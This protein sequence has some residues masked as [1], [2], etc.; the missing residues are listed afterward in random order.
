MADKEK[1][2]AEMEAPTG[3]VQITLPDYN[4][5]TPEEQEKAVK[6]MELIW[7]AFQ[8][9][10]LSDRSCNK[11]PSN[12]LPTMFFDFSGHISWIDFRCHMHG[13]KDGCDTDNPDEYQARLMRLD[14]K[15]ERFFEEADCLMGWFHDILEGMK[16]DA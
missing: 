4:M 2:P 1:R 15:K 5:F 10:G 7:M 13:Y 6:V 12:T 14:T 9:N 3:T 16:H 8:V 11:V